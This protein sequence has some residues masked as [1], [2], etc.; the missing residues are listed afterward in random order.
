MGPDALQKFRGK[1]HKRSIAQQSLRQKLM[2]GVVVACWMKLFLKQD[3]QNNFPGSS[4]R[5]HSN[6]WA[7]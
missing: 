6:L 2:R 4:S 1:L 3:L 5:G 7:R